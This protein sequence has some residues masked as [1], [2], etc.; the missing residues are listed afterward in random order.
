MTKTNY[1]LDGKKIVQTT[2]I[3][4]SPTKQPTII[5]I[6]KANEEIE[7]LKNE[8]AKVNAEKVELNKAQT[9]AEAKAYEY[10]GPFQTRYE[11]LIESK[12][13]KDLASGITYGNP[14]N[15]L[16][17]VSSATSYFIVSQNYYL[18]MDGGNV[19]LF[20]AND[21]GQATSKLPVVL[22]KPLDGCAGSG[23]S[24]IKQSYEPNTA[25][26]NIF[27]RPKGTSLTQA[28][29]ENIVKGKPTLEAL[30]NVYDQYSQ[31]EINI[32]ISKAQPIW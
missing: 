17:N 16:G 24:V 23:V 21:N 11:Q 8:I 26:K 5:N 15:P 1:K 28:D 29:L 18:F 32:D 13:Y 9:P 27:Q 19:Y 25:N 22:R 10:K 2:T 7:R 30:L 4:A 20:N 31:D 12:K 3:Q 14:V 6:T